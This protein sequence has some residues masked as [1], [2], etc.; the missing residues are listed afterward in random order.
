MAG[1]N[2]TTNLRGA[3]L[4]TGGRPRGASAQVAAARRAMSGALARSS[5]ASSARASSRMVA[6]A[7]AI[8]GTM[9]I[10]F[11]EIDR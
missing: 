4:E 1:P 10:V 9:D 2:S 11:G 3:A 5:S 7:V 8:I 6:D